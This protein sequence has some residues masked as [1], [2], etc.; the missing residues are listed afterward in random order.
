LGIQYTF[1]NAKN[2]SVAR[3]ESV[4]RLDAIGGAK[5]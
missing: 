2:V 5:V 1:N 4:A 3:A